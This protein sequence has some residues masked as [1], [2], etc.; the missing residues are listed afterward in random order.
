MPS[1]ITIVNVSEISFPRIKDL[2]LI[3]LNFL[4]YYFIIF[5]NIEISL[6]RK[7]EKNHIKI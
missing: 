2:L 6:S 3:N 4:T 7:Q 5:L 1:D